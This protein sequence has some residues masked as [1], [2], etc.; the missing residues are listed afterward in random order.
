MNN[1][2][3]DR[4]I[5][6]SGMITHHKVIEVLRKHGWDVQIAPYYYDN[7]SNTVREIDIVAE[8]QFYSNSDFSSSSVQRNVQLFIECKYI[9]QEIIFWFD[10]INKDGA[11]KKLERD[12]G[13]EILHARYGA[14]ILPDK[15]HYLS[16]DKVAKLFSANTNKEDVIYKAITQCL[17]SKIYYDQWFNRPISRDF[18]KNPRVD[19][20]II[21]YPVII[22][23]NFS[24]F[25]KAE[26]K[27]NTYEYSKIDHDFQLEVNYTYLDKTKTA[28]QGELFLI[29]VVNYDNIDLYLDTVEKEIGSIMSAQADKMI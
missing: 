24:N 4:L 22:C 15:F 27:E 11:I 6:E 23:E 5:E 29:D 10:N 17:N 13:L 28:A 2:N 14:D 7:I 20:G 16:N 1:K 19:C 3:I 26:F 12:T 8:K 25:F 18:S 21:K 9:K